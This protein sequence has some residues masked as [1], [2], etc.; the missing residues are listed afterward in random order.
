MDALSR[1]LELVVP[2]WRGGGDERVVA[3]AD[4]LA[5]LVPQRAPRVEVPDPHGSAAQ[6]PPVTTRGLGVLDAEA[7][8]AHARA[9]TAALRESRASRVVAL[10]GDCAMGTPVAGALL[11]QHPDLHVIW[12]DAHGDLNTP[13]TSPSGL[14][15]GMPLRA[16][17][18]DGHPGLV[19]DRPLRG[20]H[21]MLLG[22]REL[23]PAERDF[24]AAGDVAVVPPAGADALVAAVLDRIPAG[25]PVH[26]HLD[27][28][29]LDPEV[30]P[31][32][33]VPTPGGLDVPTLAAV[34]TTLRAHADVVGFT[35]TEY[36]PEVPHDPAPLVEVLHA[37]G[38]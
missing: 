37:F 29:V 1:D 35:V 8:V 28:D 23:D 19:P 2:L 36:V 38:A 24:L 14:A 30:F 31:A 25:A 22:V 13:G 17:L 18:G 32:V 12:V 5:A 27:L 20:D 10:G 34:A 21:T 33:A 7:V 4:A 9:V 11:D 15:Y 6:R 26:V 16:L 3:G